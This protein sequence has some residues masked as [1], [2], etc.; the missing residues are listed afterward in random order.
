MCH[1]GP[2]CRQESE[3]GAGSAGGFV[4]LWKQ[5][6]MLRVLLKSSVQPTNTCRSPDTAGYRDPP[7][8]GHTEGHHTPPSLGLTAPLIQGPPTPTAPSAQQPTQGS[9]P[10]PS[11]REPARL[12]A[13]QG[14]SQGGP[15]LGHGASPTWKATT[16]S[17]RHRG[18]SVPV[19]RAGLG[20]TRRSQE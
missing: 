2:P 18:P 6:C 4:L 20:P 10:P 9:R 19:P 17:G 1:P 5:P 15:P 14:L 3:R 11:L 13:G 12:G 16:S 8:P 7:G